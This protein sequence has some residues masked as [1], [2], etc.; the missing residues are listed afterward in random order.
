MDYCSSNGIST[1]A[2]SSGQLVERVPV[3]QGH[4]LG[5]TGNVAASSQ[6]FNVFVSQWV[7]PNVVTLTG[8]LFLVISFALAANFSPNLNDPAPACVP[9]VV[10][11]CQFLYQVDETF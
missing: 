2:Q 10:F 8:L 3:E 7:A 11:V 9:F 1:R 5:A 4:Q 6:Q